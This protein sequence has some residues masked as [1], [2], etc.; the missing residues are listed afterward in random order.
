MID[1]PD[2]IFFGTDEFSAAV[3]DVLTA[4]GIRPKSVVTVPDRPQGK[5]LW[6]APPPV[7]IWAEK[8]KIP[9]LQPNNLQT[10][11]H[12]LQANSPK[13]FLVASYGKLIPAAVFNLPPRG[14]LNIHPSLLPAYRG[15]TPIQ[16]AILDG[17]S[18]SGVTL[19]LLDAELDHGPIL[20][21]ES[22]NLKAKNYLEAKAD[23]A[24]IGARLFIEI[25]PLWAAGEIKA[26]AQNHQLATYTRKINKNDG[27]IDPAGNFLLNYRKFLAYC[28]WPGIYFFTERNGKKIRVII[29]AAHLA[30]DRE[31]V[32]DRVKPEGGRDMAFSDFR[33]GFK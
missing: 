4:A 7:K 19:M 16:T 25:A 8:N 5:H 15:P 3:L 14:A 17:I 23:L 32:I 18:E 10:V 27:L 30:D 31:F 28:D 29:T 2:F 24:K 26:L 12:R 1:F 20:K 22:Y 13:L 21:A 6:L 11:P 33:R 9:C